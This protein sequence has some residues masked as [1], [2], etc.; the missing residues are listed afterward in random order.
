MP[1]ARPERAESTGDLAFA[2]APDTDG[3]SVPDIVDNCKLV[4][5][6]TQLDADAD[7]YGNICD[8][9]LNNRRTVTTADFG[10]LR[11]VLRQS[12]SASATA[13]AADLNGSGTVTTADFVIL[14][15][16]LNTAPG[17]SALHPWGCRP[18][19]ALWQERGSPHA[20]ARHRYGNGPRLRRHGWL[21]VD[22]HARRE[23][24]CA[25]AATGRRPAPATNGRGLLKAPNSRCETTK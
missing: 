16:R 4:A 6:P 20:D 14:R 7:G 9:D 23:A 17:P 21:Y 2:P 10:L 5:N 15:A 8:A 22:V 11:S 12:A 18:D 24:R 13:A 1:P 25:E 3:D 19:D